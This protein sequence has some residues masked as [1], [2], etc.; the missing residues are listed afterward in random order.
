MIQADFLVNINCQLVSIKTLHI[1][2]KQLTI[3]K[4]ITYPHQKSSKNS[5][6]HINLT[7]APPAT[8]HQKISY[9]SDIAAKN[10]SQPKPSH[11]GNP[12]KS[13]ETS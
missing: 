11:H 13:L 5:H 2:D 8:T 10:P 7:F 6:N 9:D 1:F 3:Q 4:Y 12:R